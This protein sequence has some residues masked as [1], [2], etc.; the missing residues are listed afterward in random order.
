MTIDAPKASRRCRRLALTSSAVFKLFIMLGIMNSL[1]SRVKQTGCINSEVTVER[2]IL[3]V[4]SVVRKTLCGEKELLT[5]GMPALM[6]C[7]VIEIYMANS[8]KTNAKANPIVI[9]IR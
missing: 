5:T 9:P 4:P 6:I 8:S 3:S 2:P 1:R 7:H